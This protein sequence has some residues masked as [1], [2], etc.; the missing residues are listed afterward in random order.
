MLDR[1]VVRI[2]LMYLETIVEV[3][4]LL[5]IKTFKNILA[6][7]MCSYGEGVEDDN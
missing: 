2:A 4:F 1:Y 6:S 7:S 5:S 3:I